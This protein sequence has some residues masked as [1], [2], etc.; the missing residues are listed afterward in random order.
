MAGRV[1]GARKSR[2]ASGTGARESVDPAKL[3]ALD[4]KRV[5]LKEIREDI[6]RCRDEAKLT[7]LSQLHR[8]E[9][10]MHDEITM[11][12]D[13]QADPIVGMDADQL[14]DF[15]T[16]AI[17]DLPP[18]LQDSIAQTVEAMRRGRVVK[19]DPPPPKQKRATKKTA[20]KKRATT[21]AAKV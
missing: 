17:L 10:Q 16:G 21:R 14:V 11:A 2:R 6:Q 7:A 4:Y 5:K 3:G 12:L 15:I 8:L 19:L 13:A 9:V 20:P 1:K 18:V